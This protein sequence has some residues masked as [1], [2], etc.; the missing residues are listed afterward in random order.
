MTFH[1]HGP[2]DPDSPLYQRRMG[3]DADDG[4]E[5]DDLSVYIVDA[6]LDAAKEGTQKYFAINGSRQSGKTSL[7]LEISRRIKAVGGYP[8]R[9]DFQTAYGAAPEPSINFMARKILRAIPELGSPAKV[10]DKFENDGFGFDHWL[11]ELPIPKEK[12]VV[13]LLEE[14]G[15]L[16][17]DSRQRLGGLL[18]GAFDDRRDTPWDRVVLVFFGGIELHD[19][20]TID[21]SPLFNICENIDLLDL[22]LSATQSLVDSGFEQAGDFESARLDELAQSIYAQ[23]SGHPYLTQFLGEQFLIHS[24]NKGAL[25]TDIQAVLSQPHVANSKYFDY[26]YKSVQKYDLLK[27]TKNLLQ[28][29]PC[30]DEIA[31]RRLGLLGVLGQKTESGT[32]FRNQLI[33]LFLKKAIFTNQ[34]Q[35]ARI[36]RSD[37]VKKIEEETHLI[38]EARVQGLLD[39]LFELTCMQTANSRR[40]LL[41]KSGVEGL[42]PGLDVEGSV[43]EVVTRLFYTLENQPGLNNG[44][45]PLGLFLTSVK[46]LLS[47]GE[48]TI[49]NLIDA[50]IA[51]YGLFASKV[52][53]T[54]KNELGV[55]VSYA[56][57]GESEQIVDKLEQAFVKRGLSIVRDKRNLGYKGRIEEFEQRIGKGQCIILVISDKYLRSEHCMYELVE[58]SENRAFLNRIFPIVLTDAS[59]YEP[60]DRLDYIKYWDEKISQLNQKI[61]DM[62]LMTNLGGIQSNLNKYARIRASLDDLIAL[63][64]DMNTL[65]PNILAAGDFAALISAVE[66]AQA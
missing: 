3:V 59:I 12:P 54:I 65:T 48:E 11:W 8:C 39:R 47:P 50:F 19:M 4:Q 58:I 18:R 17:L 16:P 44:S 41:I 6:C 61:K 14:L 62:P 20:I 36:T 22:S 53:L 31:I 33:Q 55:F 45:H 43:N 35:A 5:I 46:A 32:F 7:L 52:D 40:N 49:I 13:L 51:Q 28:M 24:K 57:G 29:E 25:P 21:V 27:V 26:L 38:R 23:V 2:V 37:N 15:A 42:Q 10:P 34:P 56:W 9:I 30:A 1:Y 60:G 66:A 63:L 64:S